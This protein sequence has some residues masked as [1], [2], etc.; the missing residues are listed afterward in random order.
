MNY[1][2]KRGSHVGILISFNLFILFLLS[3][4]LL[5]NPLLKERGEKQ[6]VLNSLYPRLLE[7]ISSNMT[8]TLIK[9][10]NGYSPVGVNCTNLT[11]GDWNP[12]ENITVRNNLSQRI[13]SNFSSSSVLVPW[14][15]NRFLKFY[16]SLE[17]FESM[18]LYSSGCATPS[19]GT[20]FSIKSIKTEKYVF[21]SNI[22]ELKTM[23][24][25]SYEELKNYLNLPLEEEFGFSFINSEGITIIETEKIPP[26]V[27]VYSK[28]NY[29]TYID[30]QSNILPGKIIIKVW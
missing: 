6:P 17:N 13:S 29:V 10:A 5:I 19:E 21:E 12:A 24:D 20:D 22:F 11:G 1:F 15:G 27:S 18:P 23:Y 26:S 7:N 9:I 30:N 4:F 28:E 16:S 2:K 8:L 25:N 14:T 3:I